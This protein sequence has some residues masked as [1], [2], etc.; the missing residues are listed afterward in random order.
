MIARSIFRISRP[1]GRWFESNSR[2]QLLQS[3]KGTER[4][5]SI[6][7]K[8]ERN[9]RVGKEPHPTLLQLLQTTATS[10]DDGDFC[11]QLGSIRMIILMCVC[12][13]VSQISN[14]VYCTSV[15]NASQ[16]GLRVKIKYL[17]FS[18]VSEVF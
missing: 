9:G 6:S 13:V 3:S 8:T 2:L 10:A 14:T 11:R 15:I 16:K 12:V 18:L 5:G 7:V 1:G 17:A 4:N